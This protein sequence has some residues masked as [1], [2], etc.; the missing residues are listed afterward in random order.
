MNKK[1]F[2]QLGL[3]MLLLGPPLSALAASNIDTSDKYAWSENS[4]WQNFNDTNGGVTVYNDHLEGYA[5]AENIGWI[6]LGTHDT[7]GTHTY[8]NTSQTDY[9]VNNN[10]APLPAT[11]GVKM[12]AGLNSMI[13][14]VA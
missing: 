12:S 4:G 7:G 5:W 14:M 2:K 11:L 6:R 10:S 3:V 8:A 9:G 13:V 1:R